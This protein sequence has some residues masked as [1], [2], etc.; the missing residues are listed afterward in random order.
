MV[1]A[2]DKHRKRVVFLT[3]T[4][5]DFGKVKS[6]IRALSERTQD[7]DVHVFATGMHL[8]PKYG[9]TIRE[10][11]KCNFACE[12]FPHL[13]QASSGALDRTLANT[14]MGFGDFVRLRRPDLVVVHGDRSEALAGAV[15]AATNNILVAHIEGGEVSG[16]IDE[17]LRH[18]ISKMSHLHFVSN[19]EAK[20]RLVQLGEEP[21]AIHVIGSPDIDL[22]ASPDRPS[23]AEVREHYRIP[24]EDYGVMVWHPVTT[25]LSTLRQETQEVVRAV[26]GSGRNW[27]VIYPNSDPGSDVILA[28][29]DRSLRGPRFRVFPSLRFEAMLVL[30]ENAGVVVGNSSMG[31]GEA[32]YY[33]T[34]TVDVGSRQSGRSENPHILHV[35]AENVAVTGAIERVWGTRVPV[36]RRERGDGDSHVRF[37]RALCSAELWETSVQK[38]FRDVPIVLHEG[39]RPPHRSAA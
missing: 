28:E 27:V 6:L 22:L 18:A 34:P 31:I 29:Y 8:D 2:P 16:T 38:R 36:T 10:I 39:E 4:R 21:T 19:E 14:V 15:V 1:A 25:S 3:G 5:A 24:F 26:T 35:P 11:E 20:R 17:I 13:N 7:F 9:E 37:R 33:G 30:L 23:L 32:P 12:V